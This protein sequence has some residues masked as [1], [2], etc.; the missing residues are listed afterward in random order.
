M[1]TDGFHEK[2]VDVK[3]AVDILSG[4]YENLCDA[5]LLVSSD[6]DLIPAIHKAKLLKK[7]IEYIGFS[8][9]PS[10]AMQKHCGFTRLLSPDD[11]LQFV[12]TEQL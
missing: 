8:H 11:L 1:K 7:T 5:V 12:S 6:T 4:S 3:I 10:F 9:R 2:G